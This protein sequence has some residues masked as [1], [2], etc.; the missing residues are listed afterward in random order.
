MK[1]A[2]LLKEH[3]GLVN[4]NT[5]NETEKYIAMILFLSFQL[6]LYGIYASMQLKAHITAVNQS[7]FRKKFFTFV[8]V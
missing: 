2:I 5:I 6:H 8:C 1:L 7:I 4:R 3:N